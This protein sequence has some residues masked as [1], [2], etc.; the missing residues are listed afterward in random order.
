[1]QM[2][3]APLHFLFKKMI[4]DYEWFRIDWISFEFYGQFRTDFWTIMD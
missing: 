3:M 4:W 2:A 1:M